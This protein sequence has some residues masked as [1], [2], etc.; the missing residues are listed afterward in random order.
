MGCW[1]YSLSMKNNLLIND[2]VR[3]NH[4]E[5]DGLDGTIIGHDPYADGFEVAFDNG[6]TYYINTKD[7]ELLPALTSHQSHMLIDAVNDALLKAG[8]I[9]N[10]V[11]AGPFMLMALS[12]WADACVQQSNELHGADGWVANAKALLDRSAH[13]IR[14]CEGGGHED[15]LGSMVLTFVAMEHKLKQ[16]AVL[17]DVLKAHIK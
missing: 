12:D 15:L 16:S 2:R 8:V 17:V 4:R 9:T 14:S 6:T 13:T 10:K 3:C 11:D 7:L 1:C 5:H